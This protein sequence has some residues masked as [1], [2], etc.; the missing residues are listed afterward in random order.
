MLVD[1]CSEEAGSV[2]HPYFLA[3][4][5]RPMATCMR[6]PSWPLL[7]QRELLARISSS[8]SPVSSSFCQILT[9]RHESPALIAHQQLQYDF[10]LVLLG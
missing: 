10:P 5:D 2:H 7:I 4:H 3:L 9:F 6:W 8:T 1:M